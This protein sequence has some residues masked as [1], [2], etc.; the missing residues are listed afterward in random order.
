MIF[1]FSAVSRGQRWDGLLFYRGQ[2]MTQNTTIFESEIELKADTEMSTGYRGRGLAPLTHT[3]PAGRVV[4][5]KRYE[6]SGKYIAHD[7]DEITSIHHIVTAYHKGEKYS[8]CKIF[9]PKE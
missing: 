6:Y 7:G 4:R 5:Y 2:K 9:V 8:A 1:S 3:F